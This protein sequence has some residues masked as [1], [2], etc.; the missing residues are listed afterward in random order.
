MPFSKEDQNYKRFEGIQEFQQHS[1]STEQF[2][3]KHLTR[4]G[5]D[6]LHN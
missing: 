2:P 5:L 4:S 6:K 3:E 1:F